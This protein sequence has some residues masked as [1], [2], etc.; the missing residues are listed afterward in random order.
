MSAI[1][2]NSQI[3]VKENYWINKLSD[4]S[5]EFPLPVYNKGINS[6]KLISVTL[7]LS[8]E[9]TNLISNFCKNSDQALSIF[10]MGGICAILSKYT[11]KNQFLIHDLT[12]TDSI[13]YKI[14]TE[15]SQTVKDLIHA[16]KTEYS[17]SQKHK[18][19]DFH[20][21]VARLKD[22]DES[23]NISE[24]VDFAFNWSATSEQK[25]KEEQYNLII[26]CSRT[27]DKHRVNVSYK[28]SVYEAVV[29]DQF[30]DSMKL[31][32][33]NIKDNL[34]MLLVS[35]LILSDRYMKR[36]IEEFN[37][38][39]YPYNTE[40][41]LVSI[42]ERQALETPDRIALQYHD[43]LITYE[44]FNQLANAFAN[45]LLSIGIKKGDLVAVFLNRSVEMIV[46]VAGILK[47]GGVY[48][49]FEPSL[50]DA[51]VMKI[52]DSLKLNRLVT[53]SSH[54][55][56]VLSFESNLLTQFHCITPFTHDVS[57]KR[58]AV[59]YFSLEA[60]GEIVENP[61]QGT[62]PQDYA[63]VIHTSGSSGM[64]KGVLVKHQPVVN[65]LE[66]VNRSFSVG[67]DDKLLFVASYAFDLSV[68]DIFGI[69][70]SGGSLYIVPNSEIAE[71]A[72]LLETIYKEGI[73][74]WD[75][76]PA[77]LQQITPFLDESTR[78]KK[79]AFRLV[80]LS[81]D[82]IPVK[83][84]NAI[85]NHLTNARVISLGGATEAAIWSNFYTIQ[86]VEAW[87]KSIPYGKPIQNAKY[88]ILDEN[89]EACPIGVVGDLYIGGECLASGYIN[90]LE[91]T[92]NKFIS[93][94]FATGEFMYKTGDMARWFTDGNIEFLG[95]KDSQVKIRGH[96]IELGEIEF[97]V[98]KLPYVENA[99]ATTRN[100]KAGDKVLCVYYIAAEDVADNIFRDNLAKELPEYMVPL[101]Y[102]RVSGFPVTANGKFDLQ[103]LPDPFSSRQVLKKANSTTE[104]RLI[105]IYA[106]VLGIDKETIGSDSNFFELGGHS[107]RA[108]LLVLKIQKAFS[109]KISLRQIFLSPGIE[110]LAR[111][112][113]SALAEVSEE[114]IPVSKQAYYPLS[115]AQKRFY[116]LQKINQNPVAY[117]IPVFLKIKK[118]VDAKRVHEIFQILINRHESL[119]TVFVSKN[120]EVVQE[121]LEEVELSFSA[122]SATGNSSEYYG[123]LNS[124][125][126]PF[127][128]LSA[129]LMRVLLVQLEDNTAVLAVDMHHIISDGISLE[130]L[131]EEFIQLY[132]NRLLVPLTIQYKD[133]SAWQNSDQFIKKL[134]EQEQYW[135][136]KLEGQLPVISLPT[137]FVRP[138]VKS[139]KGSTVRFE[140]DEKTTAEL[141]NYATQNNASL[142][143]LLL[144]VF[145]VL[146]SKLSNEEDI[147]IGTPIAGRRL[148]SLQRIVGVFVN[149]I[150]LRN[151]VNGEKEFHNFFNEVIQNTLEAFENQ[152]LQ[153]ED[154]IEK[155]NVD[156]DLSRNP[157]FEIIY[158]YNES[159]LKESNEHF[160]ILQDDLVEQPAKF[161]AHMHMTG[162]NGKLYGSFHYCK[163]LFERE[164]IECFISYFR[165]IIQ[166]ILADHKRQI[167]KIEI[168]S[169]D[170]KENLL[171]KLNDTDASYPKKALHQIFEDQ[172]LK[173]P[174]RVALAMD[175]Q[176]MTYNELNSKSNQLARVLQGKGVTNDSLVGI[177]AERSFDLVIGIFAILKAGA[178]YLPIDP[179][180]PEDRVRFILKDSNASAFLTS[181]EAFEHFAFDGEVVFL[182]DSTNYTGAT[183]NV[184]LNCP[185]NNLA[186]VIYTSGTTGKP[187][188]VLIEHDQVVRLLFN[189]KNIFDFNHEDVWTLFHSPS[190]DFS[191]WEVFGALLY[192]A[193]LVIIPRL[194][195]RDP[196]KY[197]ALLKEQGVTVVNQTPSA[198]NNLLPYAMQYETNALSV[199]YIIFGGEALYPGNL[200]MWNERYSKCRI[201]NLYGITETTVHVTM[202]EISSDDIRA[203]RSNIGKPIP[204]I[205]VYVLDRFQTLV[206]RGVPGE[207]CIS[208]RGLSRGYLN[209]SVLTSE[210]FV[211]SPFV[212]NEMLYR[213]GDLVKM[214][215]NGE[216]EF[217]SRIDQQVK[218]RGH[219]IEPSEIKNRL[220]K[221]EAIRACE[222]VATIDSQGEKCLCAYYVE[223][224]PVKA[225]ELREFLQQFLPP[226][227]I[228]AF[229]IEMTAFP[230]TANGK[231]KTNELPKPL[232]DKQ[233]NFV[234]PQ[235]EIESDL[236]K[237]WCSVLNIP[238]VGV[239]DNFFEIG[240]NSLYLVRLSEL[241]KGKF[242]IDD[243][244]V[245]LFKHPTIRSFAGFLT[246]V[247]EEGGQDNLEM[248]EALAEEG[249]DRFKKM[250]SI[251][252]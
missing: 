220:S 131:S 66:W 10:F 179:D 64:P 112:C 230:L 86:E 59:N 98:N 119:R 90:Q 182:D 232:L 11:A 127:N 187:K 148:E 153:F 122:I 87:W 130:V 70:S 72:R 20:K 212:E 102:I 194:V 140:I 52:L 1:T 207:L 5:S 247:S 106:D 80:F 60:P 81:G 154:L 121:I 123:A 156:R 206:P 170:E 109:I 126:Q 162:T 239:H 54:H 204:T 23:T 236:A 61:M 228:P 229:F 85:R 57:N 9:A 173:F 55:D 15:L 181:R 99:I 184:E 188:G 50:P 62:V 8:P 215:K 13:Y 3:K 47:A 248:E 203:N 92:K 151:T 137:D 178:A 45:K 160:E 224:K 225:Q 25:I 242:Q 40:S 202:K 7:D 233:E 197:A 97:H 63:Y 138:E 136:N 68:Y 235:N 177:A 189:D 238:S 84:P 150:V 35:M 223:Q 222:V 231:L 53:D 17:N 193:K 107:L 104:E 58:P 78:D 120:G 79:N 76:A 95:R 165:R 169:S 12:L 6:D 94:P 213:S 234:A 82:W 159:E 19:I 2:S 191:V 144:S 91:L 4:L 26:N 111:Y 185:S 38:T 211:K 133:Y 139:F 237:L 208:G 41:T 221:H 113:D 42:L 217:L 180:S 110:A 183:N 100:N 30:I 32:F 176:S 43:Q 246:N 244:V 195:S 143:M 249:K 147:L 163:D 196:S 44:K 142:F 88:Y 245:A 149:T 74:F 167:S 158:S 49:P 240:G 117:N 77:A 135:L 157:L 216:L 218:I 105:D 192:G 14:N 31:F 146:V 175:N 166:E 241:V 69:L 93:N 155:L 16:V 186:Y 22:R 33:E 101:H 209:R 214:H 201:I 227:M 128:F 205:Q 46:A 108:T 243:T 21:V 145:N 198:F 89:L 141:R 171:F 115:S 18:G 24:L 51:R 129:P 36:I 116:L 103:S 250:K 125:L 118:A 199:R 134:M 65:V 48:V 67:K 219:R 73:T 56:R 152:D 172:V 200:Q 83:L 124:F 226:Y 190:F 34:N 28:E 27:K 114:I 252:Y 168:L 37:D 251:E 39:C 161:D 164:T 29:I 210:R 174:G 132:E 96:R 71:P 75:S